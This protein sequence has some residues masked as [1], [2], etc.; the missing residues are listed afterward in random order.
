MKLTVIGFRGGY[1]GPNEA[2]ST[3]LL[4]K[5]GCKIVLDFG[6]GGLLKIQN[7]INVTE[8]DAVVLSH[9]H[10]DHIADIGVLQHALLVEAQLGR[11]TKK[12]PIYG[13]NENEAE[14]NKLFDD[15]TVGIVY[16]PGAQLQIG[17]FEITFLKTVHSV[18]CF[19]MRITDGR[20][21]MVYTA[22]TGYQKEWINFSKNADLLVADTNLYDDQKELKIGHMTSTQVAKIANEGNVETLILSHLPQYG[23]NEDLITEAKQIYQGEILLAE[24]GL[25]WEKK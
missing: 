18:T 6:S 16:D 12:T 5:D 13:H 1:P 8:I 7:Y 24:E 20:K 9:Y 17:P 15:Y 25:I 2:T 3:Y 4:E 21:T 14:F 10:S 19:G 22:D 23:D 11:V